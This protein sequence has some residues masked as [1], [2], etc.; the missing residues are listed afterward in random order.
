VVDVDVVEVVDVEVVEVV[1]VEVVEV[2]DV[3]DVEDSPGGM[4]LV[5]LVVDEM[6]VSLSEDAFKNIVDVV[7]DETFVIVDEIVDSTVEV[8]S[9]VSGSILVVAG[10]EVVIMLRLI[11]LVGFSVLMRNDTNKVDI[12]INVAK[13]KVTM[14]DNSEIPLPIKF[15]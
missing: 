3:V 4:V 10:T 6:E 13:D 11:F 12:A 15:N 5:V 2:V 9:D 1:D 7:V 8:G 14:A